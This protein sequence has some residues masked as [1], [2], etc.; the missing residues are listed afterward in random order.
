MLDAIAGHP[1]YAFLALDVA[2]A[3]EFAALPV[4]RDPLD[5]LVVAAARA[6]GS[7]LLS[8]DAA[9]DGHG[10]PRVWD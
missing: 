7:R 6:T 5:R 8:A 10:V 4:V 1:G 2:Q 9:L 3:V